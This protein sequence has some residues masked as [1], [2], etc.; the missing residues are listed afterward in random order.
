MKKRLYTLIALALLGVVSL[1]A[2][3]LKDLLKGAGSGENSSATDIVSGIV[4][5]VTSSSLEY[6]DLTGKWAYNQPAVTFASDNL[7]QK[8]GG[9]AASTAAVN[10]LKPYYTKAGLTNLTIEFA[11]DSTFVAKT[12]RLTV[13]GTVETLDDGMFKFNIKALGKIPAGSIN[14]YAERQGTNIALTFDAKKLIKLIETI[15][16]LSGNS[17]LK[18][19]SDLVSSYDGIN[20]GVNLKKQK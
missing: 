18:T 14:A 16:S 19:A 12:K 20:I 6:K 2:F 9:V 13:Q 7:L 11:E 8:A 1:S 15:A 3:D 10:K 5:A 4:N 17:T